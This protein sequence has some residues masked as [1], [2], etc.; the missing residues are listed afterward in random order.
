[1]TDNERLG[2]AMDDAQLRLPAGF[3]LKIQIEPPFSPW[4]V[5]RNELGSADVKFADIDDLATMITEAVYLAI[6]LKE[7][8]NGTD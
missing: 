4:V 2:Q 6:Q 5:L 1:M 3:R 7:Q 8:D